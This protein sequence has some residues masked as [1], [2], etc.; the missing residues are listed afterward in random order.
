MRHGLIA[1]YDDLFGPHS[2]FRVVNFVGIEDGRLVVDDQRSSDQIVFTNVTAS[3]ERDQRERVH[4]ALRGPSGDWSLNAEIERNGANERR[5]IVEPKD[6]PV[7]DVLLPLVPRPLAL[8]PDMP[9]SGRIEIDLGGDGRVRSAK[10]TMTAG[11]AAW[12]R[13]GEASPLLVTDEISATFSY[14]GTTRIIDVGKFSVLAGDTNL[15]MSG[16]I[17]PGTD[18]N[19]TLDFSGSD[20]A[21][22]G[23]APGDRPIQIDRIRALG[24]PLAARCDDLGRSDRIVRQ[25]RVGRNERHL[26]ARAHGRPDR[27][28]PIRP[29][30]GT[31]T[32][33]ILAEDLREGRAQISG[34]ALRTGHRRAFLLHHDP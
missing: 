11:A 10:G 31:R 17:A 19:F 34:R 22:A 27:R 8:A 25:G 6:A 1:T 28:G 2:P 18:G 23:A 32:P 26:P 16:H 33:R 5:L 20:S 21:I 15:A 14:D 7:G 4:L 3:F 30:A 24:Y 13:P 12:N 9:V 29:H